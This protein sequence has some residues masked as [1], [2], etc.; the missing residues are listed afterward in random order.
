VFRH[1]AARGAAH[2]GFNLEIKTSPLVPGETL[3]PHEFARAVLDEVLRHR[4]GARTTIQSFDWRSL[5]AV[6]A[7]QAIAPDGERGIATVYLSAQRPD[8][9]TIR[10]RSPDGSPWTAGWVAADYCSVPRMV[11][12]AGG[13]AWSPAFADLNV[14]AVSQ[15][16]SL[17]LRV[18]PWTVNDPAAMRRLLDWGVDGIITDR[19]DLLRQAM[20][21]RGMRLPPRLP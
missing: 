1:V 3:P 19:P 18:I 21:E 5:Q 4:M 13:A 20:A 12:A 15:A 17:G 6:Q 11:K 10:L 14:Q 9:D 2:V 16:Q 7:M 8:F